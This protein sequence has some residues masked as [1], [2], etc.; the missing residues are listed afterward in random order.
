MRAGHLDDEGALD[1]IPGLG[2]LDERQAG[3]HR[4]FADPAARQ[5]CRRNELLQGGCD[6]RARGSAE[7]ILQ[8]VPP[9]ASGVPGGGVVNDLGKGGEEFKGRS[10]YNQLLA[11]LALQVRRRIFV[12]FF[13]TCIV[14]TGINALLTLSHRT[15]RCSG[16]R[17]RDLRPAQPRGFWA[18]TI[19]PL[20]MPRG[21]GG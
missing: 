9:V 18:T 16:V 3:I 5:P 12:R 1:L 8:A 19:N 15:T 20:H 2:T 4:D 7:G 10:D 21:P 17:V 6:K 13:P 11:L 14:L